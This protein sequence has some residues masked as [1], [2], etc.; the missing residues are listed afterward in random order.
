MGNSLGGLYVRYAVKILY[1]ADGGGRAAAAAGEAAGAAVAAVAAEIAVG[2]GGG[3]GVK[4]GGSTDRFSSTASTA[5]VTAATTETDI[6][7][8]TSTSTAAA[9]QTSKKAEMETVTATVTSPAAAAARGSSMSKAAEEGQ[10]PPASSSPVEEGKAAAVAA[11]AEAREGGTV[12]GLKPSVF[13]T[14]ASPHL[15]VRRFTYVPLPTPLHSLASVFVGKTGS[16]LF[17]ERNG[18]SSAALIPP[19]PPSPSLSPSAISSAFRRYFS[20]FPEDSGGKVVG[21]EGPGS[22]TEARARGA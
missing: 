21:K 14:I 6:A 22:G 10:V 1:R 2:G 7:T 9:A 15:G 4:G 17:L 16:D 12:A 8:A 13:M 3:G 20:L 18:G 19:P 5:T 11:V